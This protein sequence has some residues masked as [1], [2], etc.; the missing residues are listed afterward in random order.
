MLPD[1]LTDGI[2]RQVIGILAEGVFNLFR[3]QLKAGQYVENK[4]HNEDHQVMRIE[5]IAEG[6]GHYI[7]ENELL[8]ENA[9]GEGDGG[10]FDP[11]AGAHDIR[12]GLQ[13]RIDGN[14]LVAA[15]LLLAV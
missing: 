14:E 10:V 8:Q 11:L 15:D 9:V 5:H 2:G 12:K 6:H 7:K 4:H 3:Y 1:I 13:L